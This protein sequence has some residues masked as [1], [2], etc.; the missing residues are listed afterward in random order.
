MLT[1][2]RGASSSG[3]APSHLT[4]TFVDKMLRAESLQAFI[5]EVLVP[6]Y[7][8]RYHVMM[9]SITQRLVPLGVNVEASSQDSGEDV[10]V[11]GGFFTYLR[12]P[13]DLPAAKTVA[14]FA[15]RNHQLRI[16]FGDL[17]LVA[18][19]PGSLQRA[20]AD[21]GFSSCV[22]L[23]WAWHESDVLDQGVERLADTIRDIRDRRSRGEDL[24]S[25]LSIGVR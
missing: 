3:G 14:A 1:A 22:R 11:A 5:R 23:C 2:N 16:A 9:S 8:E 15:L 12:L 18:G 6:T 25:D 24:G 19:D 17:F 10:A 7:R 20:Q 21:D 13:S 4:S